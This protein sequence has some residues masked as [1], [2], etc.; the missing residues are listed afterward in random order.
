MVEL[1]RGEARSEL[2]AGRD[3]SRDRCLAQA[4]LVLVG[5][6]ERARAAARHLTSYK[7]NR[8]RCSL[9]LS[10]ELPKQADYADFLRN[11]SIAFR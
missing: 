4:C 3:D 10:V 5:L 2:A 7:I 6:G 9:W 8:A 11:Q 1:G